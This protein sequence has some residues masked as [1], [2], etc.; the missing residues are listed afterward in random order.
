MAGTLYLIP[1]ALGDVP[2]QYTLPE[3]GRSIACGLE[4]FL[5][6]NAKTARAELKRLGHP[7]PLRELSIEQLPEPL[8][9]I[10]IARLLQPLERGVDIGVM[11]EAGCP[12]VA[13]PGA[14]LV[15]FAHDKRFPVRPLVGASSLLLALMASGLDGQR[16]AFHGYLPQREP[17]RSR[18]IHELEQE[19]QRQRQTQLCIETPYRNR[20]LFDALLTNCRPTTMLCL[21]SDL[22]LPSEA[23]ATHPIEVWRS[24]PPPTLER[25]P[26]VFL[27]LSAA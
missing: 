12:A 22:T 19:S 16:F 14:L 18:R 4:F 11:S 24:L 7:R 10:D 13:D 25:R 9:T 1:A 21:A 5:V 15:R 3:A 26:T 2:W 17:E 27:L 6:E 8:L 23:V 20:A